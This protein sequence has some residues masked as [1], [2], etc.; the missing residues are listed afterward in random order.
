MARYSIQQRTILD[1]GKPVVDIHRIVDKN[2]HSPEGE[3]TSPHDAFGYATEQENREAAYQVQTLYHRT[4][5]GWCCIRTTVNY[6]GFEATTYLGCCSY[7]SEEDF[8]RCDQNTQ[9]YEACSVLLSKMREAV[10]TGKRAA[11]ALG[12]LNSKAVRA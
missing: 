2:E 1:R 12:C 11:T 6:D 8:V 10:F 5:W 4:P 7:E 3:P 9:V